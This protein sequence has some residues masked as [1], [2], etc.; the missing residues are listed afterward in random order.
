MRHHISRALLLTLIV[1]A[2]SC[3]GDGNPTL[4]DNNNDGGGLPPNPN[5]ML[6]PGNP[7]DI[8]RNATVTLPPSP[9]SDDE[10]DGY[11]LKTRLDAVI[12]PDATVG[13]VNDALENESATVVSMNKGDVFVTLKVPRS[14]ADAD[15]QA[16]ADRLASTDAFLLVQP[17][18]MPVRHMRDGPDGVLPPS[19][20]DSID[21][22]QLMR[23]PAAWNA[24]ELAKG[25]PKVKVL[26]GDYF[27]SKTPHPEI[28]AMRAL[29]GKEDKSE[30][31]DT[32]GGNHGPH[33]AG[34]IGADYDDKPATGTSPDP[35]NLLDIIP[36]SPEGLT[37]SEFNKLLLKTFPAT[38]KFIVSTS[39]GMFDKPIDYKD[40]IH[41]AK[42]AMEWR[43]LVAAHSDR[44]IH[45]TAAGNEGELASDVHYARFGSEYN[46]ARFFDDLRGIVPPDSMSQGDADGLNKA[47][48]AMIAAQPLAAIRLDNTIVVGNCDATGQVHPTSSVGADVIANGEY[49]VAPC[50]KKDPSGDANDCDGTTAA[51]S[52]T[53]MATPFVAGLAAY[54]WALDPALSVS[55]I[56]TI[57]ADAYWKSEN[58]MVDAYWAVLMIDA[59]RPGMK[60]REALLD[61]TGQNS[62]TPNGVFDEKDLEKF[63]EAFE[64]YESIREQSEFWDSDYSRYDLNGD[65]YTGTLEEE[66]VFRASARDIVKGPMDLDADGEI[67]FATQNIEGTD[68]TFDEAQLNDLD[69]L[70]YYAYSELYTG[71]RDERAEMFGGDHVPRE[72]VVEVE[73]PELI[74]V[75]FDVPVTI[76]AGFTSGGDPMWTEGI[77]LELWIRGSI[78][79]GANVTTDA[80]GEYST[81]LPW[82][83]QSRYVDVHVEASEGNSLAWGDAESKSP[84]NVLAVNHRVSASATVYEWVLNDLEARCDDRLDD[85]FDEIP[86]GQQVLETTNCSLGGAT[87]NAEVT[88]LVQLDAT[89]QPSHYSAIVTVITTDQPDNKHEPRGGSESAVSIAVYDEP[90]EISYSYT[91]PHEGAN[92]RFDAHILHQPPSGGQTVLVDLGYVDMPASGTLV[93]PVG[94]TVFRT[95]VAEEWDERHTGI[96]IEVEFLGPVEPPATARRK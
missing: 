73:M 28:K 55:Q 79:D 83:G 3:G 22:L 21:H 42:D 64:A 66:P 91:S 58:D 48:D 43:Q 16:I 76:R 27:Y 4:P 49:I 56:S 38:G 51:Y 78:V 17:A 68:V 37:T 20:D 30:D 9:A 84:L 36:I 74:P 40:K 93:L 82:D 33:V 6:L 52:G 8:A 45:A 65:D 63:F 2:G 90:I 32:Y 88:S 53:S 25:S 14:D 7:G 24:A 1:L 96:N 94:I 13:Q 46:A 11:F 54:L 70:C 35:Q 69:V 62:D 26:V 75:T 50:S 95:A 57:I 34:I 39:L 80:N 61:V 31:G 12:N 67:S 44:Y 18:F 19:G 10:I 85:T 86:P 72:L 89:G 15:A 47:W 77:D 29:V 81:L 41:L 87:A 71:D 5:G 59:L 23:I 92:R 60:V